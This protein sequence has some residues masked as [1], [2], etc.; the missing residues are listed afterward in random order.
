MIFVRVMETPTL[1]LMDFHGF[2]WIFIK[3]QLSPACSG[4]RMAIEARWHGFLHAL[5]DAQLLVRAIKGSGDDKGVIDANAH[6]HLVPYCSY[7]YIKSISYNAIYY[8][9]S[10]I[11]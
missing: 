10:Y 1:R 11:I 6:L 7:V 9:I 3:F 8:S 5:L 2:S 4:A